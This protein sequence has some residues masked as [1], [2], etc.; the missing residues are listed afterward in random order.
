MKLKWDETGKRF[1][2]T[3]ISHV[4]V[5]PYNKTSNAWGNGVA[6]NGVTNVTKSPDGAEPNDFWA[7]NI[8]YASIRSAENVG[9]S[10]T[11][12]QSPKE[13]D[14]CDGSV[15]VATGV[16]IGQQTRVPFCLVYRSEIG[17]DLSQEAGY[18]LNFVYNATASPT[19][20]AYDTIND[21]PDAQ[22]LS[23]DYDSTPVNVT[24]HKPTAS[25]EV[26][27]LYIDSAKL[28]LIENAIYGTD[29]TESHILLPDDLLALINGNGG[30]A[31]NNGENTGDN[32]GNNGENTG[33]NT[34]ENTGN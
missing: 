26:N 13:F 7:D 27:S 9:G 12:Y 30:N 18:K 34:G 19:E 14:I 22:E 11:A 15:E 5:F 2:E 3:G 8:K 23:W 10:I 25:L 4:V 20:R 24:G 6:W 17:N 31:G 16:N 33:D 21:S 29:E 28:T 1:Y 32:T